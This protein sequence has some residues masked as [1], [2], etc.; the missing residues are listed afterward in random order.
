MEIAATYAVESNLSL[1]ADTETRRNIHESSRGESPY[2][3]SAMINW[4][5]EYL[6]TDSNEKHDL[7]YRQ[8]PMRP[9]C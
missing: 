2:F 8:K 7:F 4:I 5:S 3:L 1:D 6:Y 9:I